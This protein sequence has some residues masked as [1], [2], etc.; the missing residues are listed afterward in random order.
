MG[1]QQRK[2]P[3]VAPKKKAQGAPEAAMGCRQHAAAMP[4]RC[5]APGSG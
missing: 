1:P 3:G 2:K 4:R 5:S